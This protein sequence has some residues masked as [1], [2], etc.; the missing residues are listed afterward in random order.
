MLWGA[1]GVSDAQRAQERGLVDTWRATLTMPYMDTGLLPG[2]ILGHIGAG[3]LLDYHTWRL[4][5]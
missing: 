2:S 5:R 3:G 1:G 4:R